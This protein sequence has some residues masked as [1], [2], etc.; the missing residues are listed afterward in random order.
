[1]ADRVEPG[2]TLFRGKIL[3]D[4]QQVMT[5]KTKREFEAE[6]ITHAK[7]QEQLLESMQVLQEAVEI[8]RPEPD[9]RAVLEGHINRLN[10]ELD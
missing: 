1:M 9:M 7:A 3:L 6:L 2:A 4:L 8:L 5:M 10:A